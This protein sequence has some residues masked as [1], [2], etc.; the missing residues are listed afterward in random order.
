MI[1]E[2]NILLNWNALLQNGKSVAIGTF[3]LNGKVLSANVAMHY[4]LDIN[5]ETL[6]Y[7]NEFVNPKFS[8][9]L[10]SAENDLVF[11]GLITLGNQKDKSYVLS[12]KVYRTDGNV[13]IFA[14]ADVQELFE[15]N[16]KM[17]ALN[18]E[19]NN[20][21]R[22]IIK[23]K[24][25]LQNT[26]NE[27]RETQQML[28]QSEK[29]NALG[30]LVAGV[31][32]ELNNPIAYVYSNLF[33]LEKYVAEICD[34]QQKINELIGQYDDQNLIAAVAEIQNEHDWHELVADLTDMTKESKSGIERIK[35]IVEDLRNFS[36]LD[37]AEVKEIDLVENIHSTVNIVRSGMQ[38]KR[39]DFEPIMPPKLILKCYPGQLN[40][41][42]MNVL[43]NA[44]DAVQINGKINLMLSQENQWVCISVTDNGSGIPDEIKSR[45]FEPFFST[46]AVGSGMGLGLSITYKIIHDLHGGKIEIN[47][48]PNKYTNIKLLIPSKII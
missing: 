25:T 29:M 33:T 38:R 30:K 7:K 36:R 31:A 1:L 17:S 11:E 4:F 47:S 28:I 35:G 2:N 5:N 46:K 10:N 42:I 45:I 41:A 12:A 23:E 19:V 13:Q 48:I 16:K 24:F 3:D 18:M 32:H 22:Q 15:E 27:L 39:I 14:E 43:L 9:F 20:L 8:V 40:Q 26:L 6:E 21:Q 44:I 34:S 37:E